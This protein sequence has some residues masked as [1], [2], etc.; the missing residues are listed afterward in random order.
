MLA[1]YPPLWDTGDDDV[2]LTRN[3]SVIEKEL[4]KERP[5]KEVILSLVR[6]TYGARRQRISAE[7]EE[8]TAIALLHE[9]PVLKKVYVVCYEPYTNNRKQAWVN[10][11]LLRLS[12]RLI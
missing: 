12:R 11:V 10:F 1:R 6:Q 5:R 9:F 2:N 3:I 4:D 8:M 7:S